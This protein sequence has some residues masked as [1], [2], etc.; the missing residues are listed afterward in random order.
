MAKAIRG[1][2]ITNCLEWGVIYIRYS[3]IPLYIPTNIYLGG[4]QYKAIA[5]IIER[6]PQ[7]VK[8]RNR[9]VLKL[10]FYL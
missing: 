6:R 5:G 2:A 3:T 9:A 7:S 8:Y 4:L 1:T 10:K